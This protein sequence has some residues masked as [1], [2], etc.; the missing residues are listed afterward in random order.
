MK[1]C[2]L[3]LGVLLLVSC[4]AQ[5]A[6]VIQ[7]PEG[8]TVLLS[9]PQEQ[10]IAVTVEIAADAVEHAKGLMGRRELTDDHGML[11]L[12]SEERIRS[13]W[14]KDTLIPLDILFFDAQGRFV[15]WHTMVPCTQDP[16]LHYQSA[17][18]ANAALEVPAGFVEEYGI[19]AG[20]VVSLPR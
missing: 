10:N 12:F 6:S 16:C 4:T 20:W 3:L 17:G 11:F 1:R 14:M 18:P 7:E 2:V 8:N 19:G 9:G 13:F 5:D 15:S